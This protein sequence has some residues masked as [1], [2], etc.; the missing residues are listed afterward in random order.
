MKFDISYYII[1]TTCSFGFSKFSTTSWQWHWHDQLKTFIFFFSPLLSSSLSPCLLPTN[2]RFYPKVSPC[3]KRQFFL[4][5]I[6]T[7]EL[8]LNKWLLKR[9][10]FKQMDGY[11]HTPLHITHSHAVL[12]LLW[13]HRKR[14]DFAV[15]MWFHVFI[16]T[17]QT[18]TQDAAIWGNSLKVT[19]DT[20][21]PPTRFCFHPALIKSK[22][23]RGGSINR[24]LFHH[25]SWVQVS[26]GNNS[27]IDMTLIFRRKKKREAANFLKF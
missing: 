3:Y 16:F 8:K 15:R 14:F 2:Q 27:I 24:S 26:P 9:D 7:D 1:V 18:G 10:H 25:T 20:N 6:P 22:Q 17:A 23:N 13:H 21:C 12:C 11:V 5:L 4:P 19:F